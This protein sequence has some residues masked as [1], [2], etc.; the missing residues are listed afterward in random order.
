MSNHPCFAW[1]TIRERHFC[2]EIFAKVGEKEKIKIPCI[3]WCSLRFFP[4]VVP[5]QYPS[6]IANN[7]S[8]WCRSL[9]LTAFLASLYFSKDGCWWCWNCIGENNRTLSWNRVCVQL[10]G[11]NSL[12]CSDC[13]NLYHWE[14]V[15]YNFNARYLFHGVFYCRYYLQPVTQDSWAWLYM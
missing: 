9:L 11:D 14:R 10:A 13:K 8:G 12:D 1:I 15:W 2:D 6:Y 7:C 3:L 4:F 5:F